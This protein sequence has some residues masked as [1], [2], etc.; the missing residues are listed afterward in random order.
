MLFFLTMFSANM[1]ANLFLNILSES[2][3]SQVR[4]IGMGT[5]AATGWMAVILVPLV[6][7]LLLK[8]QVPLTVFFGLV[9]VLGVYFCFMIK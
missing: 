4:A 7:R 3:P 1:S 8:I 9:A 2:F 6:P 5:V